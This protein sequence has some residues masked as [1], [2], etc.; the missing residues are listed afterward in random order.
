MK[1]NSAQG[2]EFSSVSLAV[3][4]EKVKGKVISLNF[5]LSDEIVLLLSGE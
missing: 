4:Q 3:V 1:E 2:F 5:N